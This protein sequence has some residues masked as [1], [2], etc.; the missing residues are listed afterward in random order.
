MALTASYPQP[1]ADLVHGVDERFV[2]PFEVTF[3]L[4]RTG[5]E[6]DV[7]GAGPAAAVELST[8]FLRSSVYLWI[9][10]TLGDAR[11]FH[12]V[13]TTKPSAMKPKPTTMFQFPRA[14]TGSS[15]WVT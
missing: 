1:V 3:P 9:T 4:V 5:P 6:R 10:L 13:E 11:H 2:R 8:Q 12:C 15:P 7:P 14:S